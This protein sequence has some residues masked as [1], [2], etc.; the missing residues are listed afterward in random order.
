MRGAVAAGSPR[1][2]EAGLS[3][4]RIGGNAVDAAIASTLMAGVAEP[5]LTGLGGAGMATVRFNGE[6]TICDMFANVPGLEAPGR[7]ALDMDTVTIDF[8]PTTQTFF[9]GSAAAAVPG[10]PAGLMALHQRFGSIPLPEL[11]APAVEAAQSGVN[12]LPGFERVSEL[13]WPILARSPGASAAMGHDN[14]PLQ[15]GQVFRAPA[16]G[17][18]IGAFAASGADYFSSGPGAKAL[19]QFLGDRSLIGAKDLEHQ[20]A[21]HRSPLHFSYRDADVWVPGPP[22]LAGMVVLHVLHSLLTQRLP[23]DAFGPETVQRLT[24]AMSDIDGFRT[25]AFYKQL[26]EAGFAGRFVHERGYNRPGPGLTTHISTVDEAGNAVAITHSLGETCG[27]IVP[28]TGILV[29]NFLGEEDVNPAELQ[30]APGHRLV[31]MCCPTIVSHRDAIYALGSGGSSRIPTAVLHGIMYLVDHLLPVGQAVSG[32][33]VHVDEGTVHIESDFRSEET[34]AT[35]GER[36]PGHVL[37]DGPNMFFGGLH[38][39]GQ[40]SGSFVGA[41][42]ARRSGS[43]GTLV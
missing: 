16:L 40:A 33:R 37:F 25:P 34:M 13:L 5:L 14:R 9:V 19:L 39:A 21:D 20:R 11:A 3:A 32:P 38:V 2:T 12:V 30:R 22:S 41:G 17:D 26:F 15:V 36:Y 8:G 43:F 31:T 7:N 4:L 27:E 29:N 10:L 24:E 42:D 1:T 18:T 6:V 28:G 35:L 23:A